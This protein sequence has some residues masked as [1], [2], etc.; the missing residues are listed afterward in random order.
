[1]AARHM[2][3]I[4]Q[5]RV[6]ESLSS[7][8]RT[9]SV[10]RPVQFRCPQDFTGDSFPRRHLHLNRP[11]TGTAALRSAKSFHTAHKLFPIRILRATHHPN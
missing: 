2:H 6:C 1:M 9:L 10:V 4:D 5:P 7:L 3:P 8:D 11:S